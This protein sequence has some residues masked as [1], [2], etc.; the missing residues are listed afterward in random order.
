M[1]NE[2]MIVK[3]LPEIEE[4]LELIKA[5]VT[6]RVNNAM[7]LV[8]TEDTVAEI[9]KIRA[10]LN[11]EYQAF[12][13]QRKAVKKAVMTPYEQFEDKYKECITTVFKKGDTDL[14]GKIDEV[15]NT[16]KEE[17][18]AEIKAYFDEYLTSKNIDFI[19]FENAGIS[20][21]LSASKKSLKEKAKAFIDRICDDLKLIDTQEHKDEIL[22]LYKKSDGFSFLNASKSITFVAEKYRAI[23]AAKAKEEERR[24]RAEAEKKAAEKV[25]TVIET[26]TPPTPEPIAPPVEEEEILT[27]K[28]TVRGS[29]TKLRA[30]KE[31]LNNGG[32]DYE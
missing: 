30:L 18:A 22:F 14:K 20:V 17:K 29:R 8:C 2:I 4:R 32:Y 23:E 31:F 25:E 27:L 19:S 5:D 15:E 13:E 21:T 11:K 7:S 10:E 1:S 12:E 26:L 9:K 24:A 16:L 6:E 28:F 3:Q